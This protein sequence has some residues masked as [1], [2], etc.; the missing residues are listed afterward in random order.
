[1]LE[2]VIVRSDAQI[3]GDLGASQTHVMVIYDR[4]QVS[5]ARKQITPHGVG[6]RLS[7]I[8]CAQETMIVAVD[9]SWALMLVATEPLLTMMLVAVWVFAAPK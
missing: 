5:T 9:L 7:R 8:Q 2:R 3:T 4:L 1:M 6:L